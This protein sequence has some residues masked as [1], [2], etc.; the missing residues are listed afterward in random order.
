M[1]NL[2]IALFFFY[3]SA[4]SEMD[5]I[6]D[7]IG[8]ITVQYLSGELS[9]REAVSLFEMQVTCAHTVLLTEEALKNLNK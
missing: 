9:E 7:R 3:S 2:L 4:D 5:K 8:L 6:Y 1:I